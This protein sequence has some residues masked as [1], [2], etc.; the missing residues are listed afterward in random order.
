MGGVLDDR[1]AVASRDLLDAVHAAGP[2]GEVDGNDRRGAR[3]DRRFDRGRVDIAGVWLDVDEHRS[4]ARVHDGVRRRAV[5][6]WRGDD[7]VA[8]PHADGQQGGV[9]ARGARGD[10]DRMLGA[11]VGGEPLLEP[12]HSRTGGQPARAQGGG[13]VGDLGFPDR[14]VPERDRLLA[15]QGHRWAP[16][17]A[18]RAGRSHSPG[19]IAYQ[20]QL[21]RRQCASPCRVMPS[22]S[23]TRS[24]RTLSWLAMLITRSSP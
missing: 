1:E 6:R 24:E 12:G 15:G 9:Q 16:A 17:R 10:R 8:G 19:P 11:D 20:S 18:A 23:I 22:L 2:A 7:L 14:R 5:R 21:L 3:A 13:D 4:G